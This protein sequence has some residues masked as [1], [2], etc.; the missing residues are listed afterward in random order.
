LIQPYFLYVGDINYNKNIPGLLHAFSQLESPHELVLVTRAM[1]TDVP[2]ASSIRQLIQELDLAKQVKILANVE[3][4]EDLSGLYSGADCYVQPSFY[5]GFGLPVLDAMQCKTPVVSS[6]G[7]S[8][9]EVVGD[10][11]VVFDPMDERSFVHAL[12]T[13]ASMSQK[14]KGLW[15]EKGLDNVRRFSWQ[16]TA[17]ESIAM[18]EKVMQ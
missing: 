2:E 9:Q 11:G 15:I 12:K 3:S 14:E 18:Y 13:A 4:N 5:E 7:G 8:L 16:K 6:N 10:A 17:A 1:K